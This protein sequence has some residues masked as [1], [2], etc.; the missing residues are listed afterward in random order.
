MERGMSKRLLRW[1]K[2]SASK[3][4]GEKCELKRSNEAVEE[5]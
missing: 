1:S 2:K 3:D 4:K 5:R